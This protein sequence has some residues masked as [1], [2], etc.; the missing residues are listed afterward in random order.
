MNYPEAAQNFV[1]A[2][3]EAGVPIALAPPEQAVDRATFGDVL[4]REIEPAGYPA[5][6]IG[7]LFHQPM[8]GNAGAAL[9]E[10]KVHFVGETLELIEK[11]AAVRHR[12]LPKTTTPASPGGG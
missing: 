4:A 3:V 2:G 8:A 10:E 1:R 11:R 7:Q 6:L 12:Y 9:R 5:R